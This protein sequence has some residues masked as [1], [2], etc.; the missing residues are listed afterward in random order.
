M[1]D[2]ETLHTKDCLAGAMI[3]AIENMRDGAGSDFDFRIM[4]QDNLALVWADD[5]LASGTSVCRCAGQMNGRS[6]EVLPRADLHGQPCEWFA[7]CD[8]EARK[9]VSH[10]VLGWVPICDRCFERLARQAAEAGGQH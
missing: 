10:P 4:A 3:S 1:N 7:L 9:R 8:R 5:Y 6:W 2:R